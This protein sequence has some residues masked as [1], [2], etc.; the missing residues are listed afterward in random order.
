MPCYLS[1][2]TKAPQVYMLQEVMQSRGYYVGYKKDSY[3][4]PVM[5][6]EVKRWQQDHGLVVDGCVGCQ[7]WNSAVYPP[8]PWEA[9]PTPTPAPS[10]GD[11]LES[12]LNTTLQQGSKGDC[13][14]ILQRKLQ[15]FGFY[16][17]KVDGDF[18][19]ITKTA[20]IAFQAATGHSQDGICGPKTWS[21]VPGYKTGG[22]SVDSSYLA[23][24]KNCQVNDSQIQNMAMSLG[25]AL[26]IFNYVRDAIEYDFYYNTRRGAIRTLTEKIGNCT[27]LSHLMIALLRAIGIPARYVNCSAV[28]F[29]SITTGHVWVEAFVNGSWV[30]LD[31]SNNGNQYGLNPRDGQIVGSITRYVELPF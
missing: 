29:S 15:E 8:C 4:G 23:A 18:G 31:A 21:S 9:T 28:K 27:D 20:V 1:L 25:G 26:A 3:F 14:T 30:R 11:T 2:G 12:C 19:P 22:G 16:N 17:A 7:T 5:E 24:T 10:P 13:V 6:R